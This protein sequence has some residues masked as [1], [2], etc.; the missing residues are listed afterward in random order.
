MAEKKE[1]KKKKWR[2]LKAVSNLLM[3]G[4]YDKPESDA[5]Y[6][7][8]P[9]DA[10]TLDV[11]IFG[12][13]DPATGK[14]AITDYS[15]WLASLPGKA[16][17]NR[18]AQYTLIEQLIQSVDYVKCLEYIMIRAC[19]RSIDTGLKIHVEPA[20]DA[21]DKNEQYLEAKR[22][23]ANLELD[24]SISDWI[25]KATIFGI[26][27][28]RPLKEK[29]IGITGLLDEERLHPKHM[30]GFK[31]YDK[32]QKKIKIGYV[33]PLSQREEGGKGMKMFLEDDIVV[34][35][36]KRT[37]KDS[38]VIQTP[39]MGSKENPRELYNL[40]DEE[41][42][43]G[44]FPLVDYGNSVVITAYEPFV[45]L[46][47]IRQAVERARLRTEKEV[48]IIGVPTDGLDPTK[49]Q[50]HSDGYAKI[51]N[52]IYNKGRSSLNSLLSVVTVPYNALKQKIDVMFNR[53]EPNITGLTDL[54]YAIARFTSSLGL[55]SSV[56][57]GKAGDQAGFGGAGL[58]D[59]TTAEAAQMSKD[60][61]SA[62][63]GGVEDILRIHFLE[64][65][66]LVFTSDNKPYKIRIHTGDTRAEKE[67]LL[68]E[69]SR[70]MQ[71]NQVVQRDVML[72]D[73]VDV[74]MAES[75]I[76]ANV[77]YL[78]ADETELRKIYKTK[79]PPPP[80]AEEGGAF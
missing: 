75:I 26:K 70:H 46:A 68:L 77:K 18:I 4:E 43:L 37:I 76:Q 52:Q 53:V 28:I 20:N 16:P 74:D 33:F 56:V 48:A 13:I 44:K 73:F 67:R 63:V 29:G 66:G 64:K 72:A 65:E 22:I 61:N 34:F 59:A 9:T 11:P 21:D 45:S 49:A 69:E 19:S 14:A 3:N 30:Q 57:A 41:T 38:S 60:S 8:S 50:E 58:M 71:V 12:A 27:V 1:K 2:G 55:D 78:H 5:E 54:E 51:F 24:N 40:W 62:G 15:T 35:K 80:G 23:I 47:K 32:D 10:N 7:Q 39:I 25:Y 36:R 6:V 42:W 31:W 17:L 79:P